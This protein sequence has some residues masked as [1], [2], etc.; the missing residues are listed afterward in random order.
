LVSFPGRRVRVVQRNETR[1]ACVQSAN[2]SVSARPVDVPPVP[3]VTTAGLVN[4]VSGGVWTLGELGASLDDVPCHA[5][6]L[7]HEFK[8]GH[9]IKHTPS[10]CLDMLLTMTAEMR[11]RTPRLLSASMRYLDSVGLNF[12]CTHVVSSLQRKRALHSDVFDR[13]S[14][15]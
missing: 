4:H 1:P 7:R 6:L 11:L 2:P 14:V 9:I 12:L 15:A 5:M 13:R 3:F 10:H 8:R